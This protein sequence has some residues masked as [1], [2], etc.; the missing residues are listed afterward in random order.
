MPQMMLECNNCNKIFPSGFSMSPGSSATFIGNESKCPYC[1]SWENIP[2]GTF[3]AT[4]NGFIDL[5]SDSK[6]PL[7][8]A[9]EILEGLERGDLSKVPAKNKVEQILKNNRLKIWIAIE[10]LRL[11]VNAWD[12][13]PNVKI[14]N[15]S[16]TPQLYLEYNHYIENTEGDPHAS[17]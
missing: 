1:Q 8:D 3:M 13:D 2:D 6:N 12:Q 14:D 16:I 11:F 5:L 10:L 15:I 9:K 17:N 4:V 7:E